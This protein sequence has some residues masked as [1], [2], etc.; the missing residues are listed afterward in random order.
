[1]G[2]ILKID[3]IWLVLVLVLV[4][5]L[6]QRPLAQISGSKFL[7]FEFFALRSFAAKEIDHLPFGTRPFSCDVPAGS[8]SQAPTGP[9]A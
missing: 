2:H 3:F 5:L 1:L 9:T 8:G 6:D 4:L 7:S